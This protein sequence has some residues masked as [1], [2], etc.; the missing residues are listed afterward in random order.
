MLPSPVC[1]SGGE[2]RDCSRTFPQRQAPP[3]A[4]RARLHSEGGVCVVFLC[5]VIR[6]PG[7]V[8][9]LSKERVTCLEQ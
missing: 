2:A 5:H 7:F 4:G 9:F 3:R 6:C 8:K 1:I